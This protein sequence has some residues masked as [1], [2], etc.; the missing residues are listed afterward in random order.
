MTPIANVVT[1]IRGA[2]GGPL[3]WPPYWRIA[4]C[5]GRGVSESGVD[6]NELDLVILTFVVE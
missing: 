3:M 6:S 5:H 2:D 4:M 1:E